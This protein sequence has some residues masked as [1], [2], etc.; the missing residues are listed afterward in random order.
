MAIREPLSLD[1][2]L[3]ARSIEL[4]VHIPDQKDMPKRELRL[5]V[6][7]VDKMVSYKVLYDDK[8]IYFGTKLSVAIERY[9]YGVNEPS[10]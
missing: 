6:K 1:D 9:N 8:E 4:A 2:L 5:Y 10:R 7:P 3:E